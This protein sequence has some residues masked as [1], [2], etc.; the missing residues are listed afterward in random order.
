MPRKKPVEP[1]RQGDGH[2]WYLREWLVA[3]KLRQADV[4]RQIGMPKAT[5]SAIFNGKTNYY[6]EV[7]NIFADALNIRPYELLMHPEDAMAIRRLRVDA[8]QI[9]SVQLAADG[10]REWQ[11]APEP[12]ELV[13]TKR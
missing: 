5:M 1:V 8:R 3:L 12:L 11:E 10:D 13:A 7:V 6:R 2:D 4:A 9:A